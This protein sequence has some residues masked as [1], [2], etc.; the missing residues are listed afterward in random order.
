MNNELNHDVFN[1]IR[2]KIKRCFMSVMGDFLFV[3]SIGLTICWAL[4]KL[5][6]VDI[7][8]GVAL[9]LVYGL[10]VFAISLRSEG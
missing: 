10:L 9:L 1:K 6:G 5:A 4:G 8:P 3:S 7:V 2:M